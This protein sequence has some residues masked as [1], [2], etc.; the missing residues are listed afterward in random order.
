MNDSRVAACDSPECVQLGADASRY[1]HMIAA[2][3]AEVAEREGREPRPA[4]PG[5]CP[6]FRVPTDESRALVELVFAGGAR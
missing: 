3:E 1:A 4:E 5:D 6:K 2:A